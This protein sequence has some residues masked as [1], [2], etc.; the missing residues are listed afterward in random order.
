V[1]AAYPFSLVG[2]RVLDLGAGPG[3]ISA[4]VLRA[5][6]AWVQWHDIDPRFLEAARHD[7]ASTGKIGFEQRDMLDL[8]YAP[9]TF[10]VVLLLG[11]IYWASDEAELLRRAARVVR[12]DGWLVVSSPNYRR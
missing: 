3:H 2:T 7:L 12:P 10:D 11:A 9:G 5:G 6:A 4:A 8:P 1:V